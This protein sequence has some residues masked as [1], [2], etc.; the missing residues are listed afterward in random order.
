MKKAYKR[1]SDENVRIARFHI[2]SLFGLAEEVAKKDIKIASD[3][4]AIARKVAM[5][6]RLRLPSRY[7]RMFCQHCHVFLLPGK[8]LRVRVHEGRLIYYCLTCK[9]FWRKPLGKKGLH[10]DNKKTI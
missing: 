7:K 5:K 9:K 4:V 8:N 2:E 10:D 3:Y 1:K 6:F